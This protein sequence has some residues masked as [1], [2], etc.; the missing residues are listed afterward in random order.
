M[1][2]VVEARRQGT[3]R[4]EASRVTVWGSASAGGVWR[5]RADG[6]GCSQGSSEGI[7]TGMDSLTRPSDALAEETGLT[8]WNQL[9][10]LDLEWPRDQS[11]VPDL[12]IELFDLKNR[13]LTNAK[14]ERKYT[15]VLGMILQVASLSDNNTQRF[16]PIRQFHFCCGPGRDFFPN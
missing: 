4:N 10:F 7:G 5:E 14:L 8:C 6:G 1:G 12:L 11:Q 15:D 9:L 16:N 3:T 2:G 13:Q